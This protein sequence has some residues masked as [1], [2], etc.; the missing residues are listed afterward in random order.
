MPQAEQWH[1]FQ[2]KELAKTSR[3]RQGQGK[4]VNGAQV[5]IHM[6]VVVQVLHRQRQGKCE[7]VNG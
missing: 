1:V 6:Q 5:R 2:E 7:A 3:Q 4:A